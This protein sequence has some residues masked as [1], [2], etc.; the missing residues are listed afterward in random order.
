MCF[1]RFDVGVAAGTSRDESSTSGSDGE[2]EDASDQ[3]NTSSSVASGGTAT[4][5][6][7]RRG[8]DAPA[9]PGETWGPPG[10]PA[11]PLEGQAQQNQPTSSSESGDDSSR[12][13]TG[14]SSERSSS[15]ESDVE[16]GDNRKRDSHVSV[17][18]TGSYSDWDGHTGGG[19]PILQVLKMT[20]IY[21]RNYIKWRFCACFCLELVL[22]VSYCVRNLLE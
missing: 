14:S 4:S 17:S 18:D 1:P 15:S 3:L 12:S 16:S 5:E 9:P 6:P 22:R 21:P 19:T 11:R 20:M 13:K 10:L 8:D 2:F 7:R